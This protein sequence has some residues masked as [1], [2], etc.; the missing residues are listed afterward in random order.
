MK[1]N[2][3]MRLASI[4]LVAVLIST[5]AISGTYAKYVTSKTGTDTARVA[6]WGVTITANGSTFATEYATD[7]ENVVGTIAKSVVSTNADKLVAPGTKGDMVAMTLT[8][9]PEVAFE[10]KYEAT[11]EIGDNWMVDGVFYCPLEITVNGEVIKGLEYNN[12]EAFEGAVKAK[13]DAYTAKYAPHTDL[14]VEDVVATPDVSWSW[15]FSTSADNDKKDTA[16]GDAAANDN[17]ATITVSVVTT[18]TQID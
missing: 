12:A 5:S 8:G 18:V 16:L 3:M 10:V 1:K 11:V 13:I 9:I 7:D 6:K 17:A 15:P 2:T 4:L 14:S